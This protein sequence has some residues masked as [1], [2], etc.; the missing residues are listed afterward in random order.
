MYTLLT[1]NELK[2]KL[3][4][5]VISIGRI[6]ALKIG[7]TKHNKFSLFKVIRRRSNRFPVNYCIFMMN[8][9]LYFKTSLIFV[10]SLGCITL[11]IQAQECCEDYCYVQD[12]TLPFREQYRNLGQRN[13]YDFIKGTDYQI[14]NIAGEKQKNFKMINVW[15]IVQPQRTFAV[16][17]EFYTFYVR[18]NGETVFSIEIWHILNF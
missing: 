11:P 6:G 8:K 12:G 7:N 2:I 16:L 18:S 1:L 5:V 15:R 9:L 13:S 10:I 4:C 14:Y 17:F 3:N